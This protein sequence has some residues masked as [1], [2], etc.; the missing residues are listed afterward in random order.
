M[1]QEVISSEALSIIYNGRSSESHSEYLTLYFKN[2]PGKFNINYVD[3]EQYRDLN[4]LRLNIDYSEDLA[5]CNKIMSLVEEQKVSMETIKQLYKSSPEI[6]KEKL[7]DPIN[8]H[9]R[10]FEIRIGQKD[11]ALGV[12]LEKG[13]NNDYHMCAMTN[14]ARQVF[15]AQS[16]K[17]RPLVWIDVGT[18]YAQ[19]YQVAFGAF[20]PFLLRAVKFQLK[21]MFLGRGTLS[22]L[23]RIVRARMLIKASIQILFFVSLSQIRRYSRRF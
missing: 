5:V 11:P 15:G 4:H 20:L 22:D 9:S 6:F 13:R 8:L 14:P 21:Q 23:K 19:E 18:H 10:H 1:R 7:S 2:N 3:F 16:W 17:K 12:I